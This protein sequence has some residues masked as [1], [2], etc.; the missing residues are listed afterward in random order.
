M[1]GVEFTALGDKLALT[2]DDAILNGF[3]RAAADEYSA[4]CRCQ[5]G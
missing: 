2:A 5:S 4:G 1:H 3:E